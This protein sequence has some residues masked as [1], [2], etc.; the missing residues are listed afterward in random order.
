MKLFGK[1]GL[2][3]AKQARAVMQKIITAKSMRAHAAPSTII[4]GNEDPNCAWTANPHRL[5]PVRKEFISNVP[6][7]TL[8][9][10]Q[11]D[12]KRL[13]I[14]EPVV[15]H[16]KLALGTVKC[17]RFIA[18]AFFRNRYIHRAIV[19]ETVAAVPGMVAGML[20]HLRSLRSTVPIY[21]VCLFAVET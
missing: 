17:L 14:R 10:E 16:D 3:A 8:K 21:Y 6:L 15:I 13:F 5:P 4:M 20:R 19:L 18:D 7:T 9:L 11:I 2:K 1:K 12:I